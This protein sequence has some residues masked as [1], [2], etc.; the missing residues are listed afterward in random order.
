M[1]HPHFPELLPVNVVRFDVAGRQPLAVAR[2]V[3]EGGA[4]RSG[5]IRPD[6]SVARADKWPLSAV[7][8]AD[9]WPMQAT[10]DKWP[11]Q[12]TADKWPMAA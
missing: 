8:S 7:A 2:V 5:Q 1:S 3:R 10:S 6:S 9:K 11:M 4:A 12:A